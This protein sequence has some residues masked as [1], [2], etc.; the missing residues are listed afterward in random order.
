MAQCVDIRVQ[1]AVGFCPRSMQISGAGKK[2]WLL[3]LIL[4]WSSEDQMQWKNKGATNGADE[5]QLTQL[6]H[7]YGRKIGPDNQQANENSRS[8][9]LNPGQFSPSLLL[10]DIWQCLESFVFATN[11]RED[12]LL[13]SSGQKPEML[14]N[15]LQSTGQRIIWP[16]MPM[17]PQLRNPDQGIVHSPLKKANPSLRLKK[18]TTLIGKSIDSLIFVFP[19]ASR[20]TFLS[21]Q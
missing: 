9:D 15:T 1:T 19:M 4:G 17:V 5:E 13:A 6:E 20:K 2:R 12:V 16:Q 3:V 8:V 14:L 18:K 21:Q 11:Q 10:R 7:G